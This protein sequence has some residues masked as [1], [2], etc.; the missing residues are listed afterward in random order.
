MVC[1]ILSFTQTSNYTK[2]I[3]IL[4]VASY[5]VLLLS[6]GIYKRSGRDSFK[7]F[8]TIRDKYAKDNKLLLVATIFATS[9]GG[10][11]A[12]GISEK[13]FAGNIAYSY[14]LFLTIPI[15]LLIAKHLIPRLIKHYGAQTVGDIMFTYYGTVGRI[16]GGFAALIVCIG[17]IAAQIS[18]SGRI[19]Q[20]ILQIDYIE[21]VIISYGV[22]IIYTTIGGLRSVLFTNLLQFFAILVAIPIVSIVGLYKIGIME[23]IKQIPT[24]KIVAYNDADFIKTIIAAFLGFTVMNLFPTYIQ[25]VLINK[26][27]EETKKAIYIKSVIYVGFLSLVTVNGLLSFVLCP[28]ATANIALP[29][30]IDHIIPTGLQGIVVVGLL[31][32]VMST[33]DSDLNVTSITLVKD[34]MQPMFKLSDEQRMLTIAR[35]TNIIIGGLSILIA[36]FFNSVIDLVIFIAGFWGPIILVPLVLGLYNITIS[37][38]GMAFSSLCGIVSF[39]L[40]E[41]FVSSPV[42]LKGVFIGTFVNFVIFMGFYVK[43]RKR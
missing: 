8:S 36:L 17:L 31:A 19:F 10:G 28:E 37:K 34:F 27:T 13:T 22:V 30:L 32:A 26:N 25:R 18:V 43:A 1:V 14:A 21:G 39:V 41:Y 7:A 12:F 9:I 33:A 4:I 42:D 40:W 5:L 16:I 24:E 35:I 15:D 6:I 3:D 23:F 29:Y 20:Y 2:M 11:A 38:F